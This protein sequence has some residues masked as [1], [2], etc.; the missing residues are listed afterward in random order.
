MSSLNIGQ[1]VQ[2]EFKILKS[3]PA[4]EVAPLPQVGSPAP[5]SPKLQL[6]HDKPT[7]VVFLRHC[8][9]PFAE[10]T[11]KVLTKL[12]NHHRDIHCVAV[13]HSSQADTEKWI[14]DIGGEWEVEVVIDEERDV[15]AAWGLGLSS[16]WHAMSPSA[17]YSAFRLGKD[18]GLW[19]RPTDSGTMWQTSGAFA[20]DEA[21]LVKFAHV[22]RSATDVPDFKDILESLGRPRKI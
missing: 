9:D 21:G 5:S 22:A 16:Y 1:A 6:P 19:G 11:F 14:V 2:R 20:V 4:K 8:G 13:S 15:Y 18:E 12:S 17:L 7:I 3:P 10:K